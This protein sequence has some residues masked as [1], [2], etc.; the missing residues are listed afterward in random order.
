MDEIWRVAESDRKL[1][2]NG[3]NSAEKLDQTL[4]TS[5]GTAIR[6]ENYRRSLRELCERVGVDLITPY[7]LRHTAGATLVSWTVSSIR[8]P[9]TN[10]NDETK[11]A[12]LPQLAQR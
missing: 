2:P 4:R 3:G 5:V 9:S 1:F 8:R 10:T 7:E 6:Q 11:T 12:V